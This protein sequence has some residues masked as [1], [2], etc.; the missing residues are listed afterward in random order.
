MKNSHRCARCWLAPG[1]LSILA[2]AAQAQVDD[3]TIDGPDAI[4]LAGVPISSFRGQTGRGPAAASATAVR[5]RR[6]R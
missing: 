2:G 4:Y 3:V 5:R 1:T 6:T